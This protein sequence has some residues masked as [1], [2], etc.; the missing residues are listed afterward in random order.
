MDHQRIIEFEKK[1]TQE[2][3]P[4]CSAAC[5]AH[6]DVRSFV[7][8]MQAGNFNDAYKIYSKNIPFPGIMSRI[9]DHPCQASCKRCEAGEAVSI[10]AL[11]EA[12]VRMNSS[13][14][15]PITAPPPKNQQV[16]VVGGG[17]S[18]L[19]AAYYLAVKG[20]P[21][22]IFEAANRLGGSLWEISK[23]VLPGEI[24]AAE[25]AVLD[26]L[27]VEIRFNNIV[28]QTFSFMDLYQKYDAVYLGFVSNYTDSCGLQQDHEG[29]MGI[30]PVTFATSWKGVFAGGSLRYAPVYSPIGSLSDARRAAISIDRYL[31]GVSLTAA[32][33]NEGPYQTRLFTNTWRVEP[34][35]AVVPENPAGGYTRDEAVQEA[36]R[37]LQ[38]QCLEC[39]KACTYLNYFK[40][41]PKKYVRQINHNLEMIMGR[42]DA[43]TLINS[44]FMCGLCQEVCPEN[45]NMGELCLEA[46]QE[47][48]KKGKMPPSA[49]DFP[50]R[51]MNF[52]N[53]KLCTLTRHQPGY[54]TSSQLFFPGCQLSA[55]APDHVVKAYV[56][57]MDKVAGGVGLML[58]CCGAPAEWSGRMELFQAGLQEIREQWQAMGRP[59]MIM[60]CSTC[61]QMFKKHL[62]EIELMSLWEIY[63]QLGL[64]ETD[65]PKMPIP[66]AVHD[67]CTARHE[68]H[69]H[70]S[71][72]NILLKLGCKIEELPASREMTECCG[73]GGMVWFANRKL[74]A[75]LITKRISESP[76]DYVAYCAIC[77]DNFAAKGKKT[78]YLLDL[79]YGEANQN[80][81]AKRGPGYSQRRENRVRLKNKLLKEFWGEV[82]EESKETFGA[83]KLIISGVVHETME[84]RL[85]LLEDIQKV[86][87]YA[88][89]TGK[90]IIN[91]NNGHT[92]ACYRPVSVTYWV[93]Y[94]PQKDGFVVHN[95]YSHRMVVEGND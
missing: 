65:R 34:L 89:R 50:L 32:R 8:A 11:E 9:C 40:S 28:G 43:N 59:R 74:A 75:E 92:L 42:H 76:A 54:N 5:P 53:S 49:H 91:R 68:P 71:V 47:M 23:E 73:Y 95:T 27:G 37:C 88:E 86:I 90:K 87:A 83:L 31:Q 85:I 14:P 56:Y 93:E 69:M 6:V 67:A 57:L 55:S 26:N 1:C 21:V 4:A 16:A 25:T 17:L 44:C 19:T 78:Y 58:R 70:A 18:G 33:E 63:D 77:R 3:P 46:R 41:Y 45:F 52:S 29:R 94:T 61:Y 39:I 13:P 48:V 35:L 2:H 22:V 66:V 10:A 72:R 20:Y 82:A 79:I 84:E 30:D 62:P 7:G 24:I 80:A 12:C 15:V 38:C 36:G 81:P 64:P 51:D 60:A